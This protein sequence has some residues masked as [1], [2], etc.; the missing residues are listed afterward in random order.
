MIH[1][2]MFYPFDYGFVPQT[3][4]LDGDAVDVFLL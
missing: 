3:T 2:S 4:E 1:H